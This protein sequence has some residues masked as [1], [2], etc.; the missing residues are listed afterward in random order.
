MVMGSFGLRCMLDDRSLRDMTSVPPVAW[1][2]TM[3]ILGVV[4]MGR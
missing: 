4:V 1:R 2:G 3:L